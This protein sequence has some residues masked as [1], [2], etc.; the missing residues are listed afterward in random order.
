MRYWLLSLLLVSIASAQLPVVPMIS[1]L[2]SAG[3]VDP[4]TCN[5][6]AEWW[7]FDNAGNGL[8]TNATITNWIGAYAGYILTNGTSGQR[9]T[10]S[11]NGVGFSGANIN[12]TNINYIII[13]TNFAVMH[14]IKM[15]AHNTGS[16]GI[17]PVWGQNGTFFAV[18]SANAVNTVSY[19]VAR[20][21]G[22]TVSIDKA[23]GWGDFTHYYDQ[24]T[25]RSNNSNGGPGNYFG[26]TNGVFSAAGAVNTGQGTAIKFGAVGAVLPSQD[27]FTT[28]YLTDVLVWTNILTAAQVTQAHT[29]LQ[30]K[31]GY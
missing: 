25:V 30:T 24:I 17:A 1:N 22:T 7:Q 29:A 26:S 18:G 14:V 13:G 10:N 2:L 20:L 19:V 23:T 31:R 3:V 28:M 5:C 16:F 12:L 6:L 4:T 21:D 8:T 11:A 9:P 27:G 15:A